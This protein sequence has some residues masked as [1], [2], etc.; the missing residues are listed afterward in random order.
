MSIAAAR[1]AA[2]GAAARIRGV[3]TSA[4][5]LIEPG[6]A[7]IQD[8]TAAILLRVGDEVGKLSRGDL[9]EVDGTRSTKAGMLSLRVTDPAVLI[10]MAPEPVALRMSTGSVGESRE[11]QL[12]TVRGAVSDTPRKSSAGSISFGIDDGSGEVRVFLTSASRIP[13]SGIARGAWV[14]VTGVL[15]QDTTGSQPLRGYRLLPRETADLRLV[16]P[17]T[18]TQG[19]GG[20]AGGGDVT[21]V[22]DF[23]AGSQDLTEVGQLGGAPVGA[24]LVAGPWPELGLAGLLWD[25][26]HLAGIDHSP[27]AAAA[28]ETVIDGGRLPVTVGV[29]AT[30]AGDVID[31]LGI[32]RLRIGTDGALVRASGAAAPPETALDPSAPLWVSITGRL[33]RGARG[34]ELVAGGA[35]IAL[36]PRCSEP[37]HLPSGGPARVTGIGL[38]G[39][40]PRIVVPCGGVVRAPQLDAAAKGIAMLTATRAGAEATPAATASPRGGPQAT[41]F[42]AVIALII[43]A[44][45]LAVAWQ[46]GALARWGAALGRPLTGGGPAGGAE[47]PDPDAPD[48]D[49]GLENAAPDLPPIPR[50]SVVRVHERAD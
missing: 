19:T 26:A 24:T 6:S 35:R 48:K 3:V 17:A 12:I 42:M 33:A 34:A 16:A 9:V 18:G 14:E 39:D 45:A 38:G 8:A 7:V 50:L 21:E 10:G 27:D 40:V 32:D 31:G 30:A 43:L 23:E 25:G 20:G 47:A 29:V 13:A 4:T 37:T 11:A 28:V 5:G 15:G 44:G 41:L 22:P 1:A 36:E 49:P 46:Q 2:T